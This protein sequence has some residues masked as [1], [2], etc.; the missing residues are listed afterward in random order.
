MR[1]DQAL[2]LSPPK[3]S[4]QSHILY[5]ALLS[6]SSH[7]KIQQGLTQHCCTEEPFWSINLPASS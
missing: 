7:A 4:K 6:S 2:A 1:L 5:C 3:N